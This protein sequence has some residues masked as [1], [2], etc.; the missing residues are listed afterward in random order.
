MIL[1]A[2]EVRTPS[3]KAI[4]LCFVSD[5]V[6]TVMCFVITVTIMGRANRVGETS[7]IISPFHHSVVSTDRTVEVD[8][9]ADFGTVRIF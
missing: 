3:A 8:A 6:K 7:S 5:G 2:T 1:D 9:R 4:F